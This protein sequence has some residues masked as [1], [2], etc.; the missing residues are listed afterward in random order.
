MMVFERW[1]AKRRESRRFTSPTHD[2]GMLCAAIGWTAWIAS[3][4]GLRD[5][6][7]FGR[8]EW[9]LESNSE[10]VRTRTLVDGEEVV[11]P[12]RPTR[13]IRTRCELRWSDDPSVDGTSEQGL[14]RCFELAERTQTMRFVDPHGTEHRSES[15]RDSPAV[16]SEVVFERREGELA[17][18]RLVEGALPEELAGLRAT[19]RH[20]LLFPRESFEAGERWP[21][22][23][24]W[25]AELREAGGELAWA[26]VGPA[27]LDKELLPPAGSTRIEGRIEAL[28]LAPKGD[29]GR[30]GLDFELRT[31]LD[32]TPFLTR[33]ERAEHREGPS[34]P[35]PE[36]V[37]V[38]ARVH[39]L[40]LVTYEPASREVLRV[41][42]E[43]RHE[44]VETV[45]FGHRALAF[46]GPFGHEEEL[47]S[48]SES[49]IEERLVWRR[50]GAGLEEGGELQEE[51]SEE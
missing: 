44:E 38:E 9:S 17:P 25:L 42:L 6:P 27:E 33:E 10:L 48:I 50:M 1:N 24:E 3:G 45:D 20:E 29:L 37:V 49:R 28:A 14:V 15:T 34:V 2:N 11:Q 40:G 19:P 23:V 47:R 26:S 36:S 41:E 4:A 31:R 46:G 35:V 32:L 22:E 8:F 18:V 30:V 13:T 39:G 51:R 12:T 5:A 43:L 21:V 16:G 7:D